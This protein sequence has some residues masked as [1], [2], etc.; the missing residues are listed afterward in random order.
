LFLSTTMSFPLCVFL[1]SLDQGR[2]PLNHPFYRLVD[3]TRQ[4]IIESPLVLGYIAKVTLQNELRHDE[5]VEKRRIQEIIQYLQI[6]H[7][8]V[9]S[10]DSPSMNFILVDTRAYSGCSKGRKSRKL[11]RKHVYI[12]KS[13]VNNWIGVR[14]ETFRAAVTHPSNLEYYL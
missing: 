8:T 7:P 2:L 3:E 9:S 1:D 13:L 5:V 11:A 10:S 6:N 12:Q 4:H 14:T